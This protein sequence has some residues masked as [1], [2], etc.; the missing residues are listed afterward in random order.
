ML[1]ATRAATASGSPASTASRP[2]SRKAKSSESSVAAILTASATPFR[3]SAG[4]SVPKSAVSATTAAGGWM[5]P[6]RFF[7]R[8]AFTP[9]FPPT[10]ASTAAS[11]V[12]GTATKGTPRR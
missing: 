3:N 1:R 9:V 11:S 8:A 10:E 12:V 6:I 4:G 2:R 7:P 5:A